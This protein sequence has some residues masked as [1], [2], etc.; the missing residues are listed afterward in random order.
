MH[1]CLAARTST[2]QHRHQPWFDTEC[3][4]KHK[5]VSAYAKLHPD[6]HL[7]R[8]RKKQLKQLLRRKKHTYKK[9]QG[10]QLCALAKTDLVNFWRQ[11]SKSKER[12]VAISKADLVAGFQKLLEGQCLSN[13]TGGQGSSTDQVVSSLSHPFASDDYSTLNCDIT[14]DEIVQVMRRLK[15]NKSAGLNGIKAKF[16]LDAGDMLHVPLQIVFN[17]LLQ[18]GYSASLSTRVIHA[19]H[20]GGDAL[21]FE[22]YRGIT[23]GP[24]LAK[25]FAMILEA[26]LSS[27]AEERGL[28]ARGQAGFKK[29]FRTTDNLYILRT[30]I[31]QS[32]H[33]CKKVYCCFV[34]FRKAFDT[35]PRDLLWQVLAKMGIVGRFMQCLQSM[36]NQDNIRVMHPIEGLSA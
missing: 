19:L 29:D 31:E 13:T 1:G 27:W 28:R 5:E 4:S 15:R 11:Y 8:E 26:R 36:Y 9:L 17:K 23:V 25:V 33:K 18:Q 35:V 24:V 16:L 34:D 10:R 30:L 32:A 6:N 14:L 20:K 7:A 21:Q 2:T 12:S 22:N 3:R